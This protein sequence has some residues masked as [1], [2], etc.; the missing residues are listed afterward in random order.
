MRIAST[1][2]MDS[3]GLAG[4][5]L[6]GSVAARPGLLAVTESAAREFKPRNRPVGKYFAGSEWTAEVARRTKVGVLD[7]SGSS[8]HI[9]SWFFENWGRNGFDVGVEA[10]VACRGARLPRKYCGQKPQEPTTTS[11][12]RW[13]PKKRYNAVQPEPCL[14]RRTCARQSR[15]VAALARERR[16]ESS[17]G[18]AAAEAHRRA[19]A[20]AK[21]NR[22]KRT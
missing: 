15:L 21:I 20:V 18:T 7:P 8:Q 4:R 6:V 12:S 1:R 10:L 22:R 13:P 16:D 3:S 14:G 9:E 2:R 11:S 17:P 5:V 19:S